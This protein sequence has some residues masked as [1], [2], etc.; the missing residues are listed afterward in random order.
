MRSLF[1][2]D[3]LGPVVF[4]WLQRVVILCDSAVHLKKAFRG[5]TY[6]EVLGFNLFVTVK[7]RRVP[8][9]WDSKIRGLI[10]T[11][12]VFGVQKN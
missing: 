9:S 4:N 11:L 1:C 7:L 3:E 6:K 10:S 12:K 5:Y 8:L 2:F